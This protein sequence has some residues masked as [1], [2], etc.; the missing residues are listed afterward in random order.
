MGASKAKILA[1]LPDHYVPTTVLLKAAMPLPEIIN[2]L[3]ETHLTFPLIVKP[4]IGE[5]GFHVALINNKGEL[6]AH[7]EQIREDQLIQEY[8]DM[9]VELGIFYSRF[10]DQ[11]VGQI[12]SVVR[13]GMLKVTGNGT[14]SIRSLM[15]LDPRSLQQI[16]RLQ[17]EGKISLDRVLQNQEELL[18]E[19]IGNHVRGTKF[20]NANE[21]INDQLV[22]IFNDLAL[23]I[24]GF[25]Y[26]RF[27]IRCQSIEALY[28]GYFKV[29]EVNGAASEPAHIYAPN[30][31]ILKGYRELFRHWRML[32]KIS[33]MNHQ[34]G[35]KY[36]SLREASA[37]IK[38]SRFRR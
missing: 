4:D 24:E 38:K 34:R 14:S 9:P 6:E 19:P 28:Q 13:K 7:L 27:D 12:S 3:N 32:Y 1:K 37:A 15:E 20:I 30:Y 8:L 21:L 17:S 33:R 18:L 5:R 16:S 11:Q 26:G 31:P 35:V 23:Q 29:M 2:L 36:M 25:Y 10:P 22:S